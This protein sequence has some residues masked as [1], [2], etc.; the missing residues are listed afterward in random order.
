MTEEDIQ[1]YM[2]MLDGYDMSDEER[3]EY[4]V[5][6]CGFVQHF[7]D[8]AWEEDPFSLAQKAK[9]RDG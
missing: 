4:V 8:I 3:R 2:K 9:M 6:L 5:T 7:V 1:K